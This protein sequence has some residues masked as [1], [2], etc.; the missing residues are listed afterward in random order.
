MASS[1]TAPAAPQEFVIG[2]IEELDDALRQMSELDG[3]EKKLKADLDRKVEALKEEFAGRL[4][5]EIDGES[6]KFA[7]RRS[8]LSDAIERFASGR[9]AEL[10]PEKAKTRKLN[11]GEIG[12]KK[13]R[14]VVAQLPAPAPT[15]KQPKPVTPYAA[16]CDKLLKALQKCVEAFPLLKGLAPYVRVTVA[17]DEATLITAIRDRKLTDDEVARLGYRFVEGEDEF[18]FKPAKVQAASLETVE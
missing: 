11:H 9:K 15:K 18:F 6:V 17:V 1:V 4:L 13:A 8:I 12:W 10:L 14:D 16:L 3:R 5:V 7:D 2:S